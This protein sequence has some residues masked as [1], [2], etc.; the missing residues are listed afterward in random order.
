MQTELSGVTDLCTAADIRGESRA[1]QLEHKLLL[2][3]NP[4]QLIR[5]FTGTVP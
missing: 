1:Y 4:S 2:L 5:V 3:G